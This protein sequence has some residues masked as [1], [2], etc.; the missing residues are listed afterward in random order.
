MIALVT[1]LPSVVFKIPEKTIL[2]PGLIFEGIGSNVRTVGIGVDGGIGSGVGVGD[3]AGICV[4][5]LC[6]E[7]IKF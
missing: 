1:T 6:C 4:C 3:G 2:P 5:V 7:P